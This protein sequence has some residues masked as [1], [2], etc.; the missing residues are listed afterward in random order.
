[1]LTVGKRSRSVEEEYKVEIPQR[2]KA[3]FMYE[4]ETYVHDKTPGDCCQTGTVIHKIP[5]QCCE[6][7]RNY[8]HIYGDLQTWKERHFD[9]DCDCTM[10]TAERNELR[11]ARTIFVRLLRMKMYCL[12]PFIP[13]TEYF[14]VLDGLHTFDCPAH[15]YMFTTPRIMRDVVVF[16]LMRFCTRHGKF[17]TIV[18]YYTTNI[19]TRIRNILTSLSVLEASRVQ[20]ITH[21]DDREE[22]ECFY[23]HEYYSHWSEVKKFFTDPW[24]YATDQFTVSTLL[25]FDHSFDM[26]LA[27]VVLRALAFSITTNAREYQQS[28]GMSFPHVLIAD[29]P[30]CPV[31]VFPLQT[32]NELNEWVGQNRLEYYDMNEDDQVIWTW[33]NF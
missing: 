12:L 14:S 6:Y 23:H 28:E 19:F 27:G 16:D 25:R 9:E 5:R 30:Q 7:D 18:Y 29:C 10:C 4:P 22:V 1:M 32:W 15:N 13:N 33:N 20:G 17:T 3:R 21:V 31:C 24:D 26:N 2:E 8:T 11:M